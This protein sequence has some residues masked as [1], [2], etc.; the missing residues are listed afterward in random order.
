MARTFDAVSRGGL[1]RTPLL[2]ALALAGAMV[3]PRTGAAQQASDAQ[4]SPA[5]KACAYDQCAIRI[6]SSAWR[7]MRV[8]T[9]TRTDSV[10]YGGLGGGLVRAVRG[11]PMAEREAILGRRNSGIALAWI[12]P[13]IAAGT[14]M[15]LVGRRGGFDNR[16]GL[17]ISGTLVTVVGST[18]GGIYERR[19]H[20]HFSRAIWHYNRELAR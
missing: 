13:A 5:V 1:H 17:A 2:T 7:G 11:V 8:I 6:E 3:I 20:N 9:G 15:F 19:S 12:L 10:T 14:T 16:E 4:V 18:I